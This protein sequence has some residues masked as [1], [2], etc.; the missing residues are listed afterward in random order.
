MIYS[1]ISTLLQSLLSFTIMSS[2]QEF[3]VPLNQLDVHQQVFNA[4]EHLAYKP[5]SL[6]VPNSTYSFWLHPSNEVNPLAKEGSSGDFANDA[7]ICIIGSGITGV[8]AAYRISKNA[9]EKK[10]VVLEARDFC[11]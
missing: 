4:Q 10:V 9:P 1:I 8:S 5:A 3:P 7:D 11:M 6:P 2:R